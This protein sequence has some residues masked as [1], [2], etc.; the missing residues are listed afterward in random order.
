M[1]AVRRLLAVICALAMLTGCVPGALPTQ[2]PTSTT[3]NA[4]ADAV[5][6]IVRDTMA[7]AHLKAVI[8]RVTVDG[9]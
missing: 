7:Q 4:K 9:K 5:M 1:P 3:E 6:R 8:V 2:S